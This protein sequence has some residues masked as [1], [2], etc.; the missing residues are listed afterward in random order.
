M[1]FVTNIKSSPK[2]LRTYPY[3]LASTFQ[4]IS[5]TNGDDKWVRDNV[6]V[7][8]I[9][10]W[11]SDHIICTPQLDQEDFNLLLQGSNPDNSGNNIFDNKQ[12]FTDKN[13]LQ[14]YADNYIIDHYLGVAYSI[15]NPVLA[16]DWISNIA[17]IEALTQEGFSDWHLPT[18]KQFMLTLKH[19]DLNPSSALI[20]KIATASV[21]Q[22]SSTTRSNQITQIMEAQT[23]LRYAFSNKTNTFTDQLIFRKAFEYNVTTKQMQLL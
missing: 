22:K 4:D 7:P 6:F 19:S 21:R 23:I 11:P 17:E 13:G 2:I 5:Y 12:R 8:E 15:F 16:A 20:N 3:D 9:N 14:V 1:S 10:S 18:V